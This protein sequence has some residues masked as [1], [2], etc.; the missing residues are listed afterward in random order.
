GYTIGG[1]MTFSVLLIFLV[2][3]IV[4]G[5]L[6]GLFMF[7][8]PEEPVDL[9]RQTIRETFSQVL[10]NPR[11]HPDFSILWVGKLLMQVALAFLSTYQLYF[12]LDRLGFTAE[13]AGAKLALVGGI[14]IRVTMTFAVVSGILSDRL[15]RR[16][17]FILMSA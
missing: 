15:K 16:R 10:F 6:G 14:G 8:L 2:P 3:V 1:A 5:V 9:P 4:L 12:R 17:I 13:E 7:L 11:R